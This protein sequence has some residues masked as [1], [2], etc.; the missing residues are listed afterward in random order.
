MLDQK[1]A[2]QR[3]YLD[4]TNQSDWIIE[5]KENPEATLDRYGISL[6]NREMLRRILAL[7]C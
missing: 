4:L 5:Y 1:E 6:K 2:V 3:V 7:F